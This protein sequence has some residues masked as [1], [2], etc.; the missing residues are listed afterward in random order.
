LQWLDYL[1]RF[2]N[3]ETVKDENAKIE[4][5]PLLS[6]WIA[7]IWRFIKNPVQTLK[8]SVYRKV[9]DTVFEKNDEA[10]LCFQ[11]RGA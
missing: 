11:G 5:L 3:K 1:G 7:N 8:A 4:E 9:A 2:L 6:I 10:I